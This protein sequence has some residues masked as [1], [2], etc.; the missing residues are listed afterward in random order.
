M[1]GLLRSVKYQCYK[2][3]WEEMSCCYFTNRSRDLQVQCLRLHQMVTKF[4]SSC[5]WH[6][7]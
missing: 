3:Q 6:G 1:H 2:Q 7:F 4:Q 5:L